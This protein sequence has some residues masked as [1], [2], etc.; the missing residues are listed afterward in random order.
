M[1]TTSVLLPFLAAL[2]VARAAAAE[3]DAKRQANTVILDANAVANLRLETVVAEP[4]TFEETVF[5]L[6]RI[7][8]FPGYRGIVS[9]RVPGRIVEIK[10]A[11]DHPIGEGEVALVLEARQVDG[12]PPRLNLTAP[13]A[14]IVS[15]VHVALGEP[16]TP[17]KSLLEIVDLEVV[18]AIA[19]VPEHSAARLAAGQAA[20]ITVV[21]ASP[22]PF[23]AEIKHVGTLA[24]PASGTV[25][26]AFRVE[27]PKLLLRPGMRAEFAIVVAERKDVTAVPRAAIQ[28]EGAS[29]FVFV[30]D[31]ALPNAFVKCPVV[32]GQANDRLVEIVSGL[33]PADEVVTRGAYSLAFAG[34]G[35]VSLKAALD[36]AHGHE[37][38]ADGTELTE[39]QRRQRAAAK[40]NSPGAAGH[41]HAHDH[42]HDHGDAHAH[43]SPFWMIVSGALFLALI[44]Q[45]IRHRRAS[46]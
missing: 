39:E 27:N 43:A 28:G 42:G 38:N 21:A 36:A 12:D 3:A 17:E 4:A 20:R 23:T 33:L 35:N 37:H 7:E 1:K 11:P 30:T 13:I 25:E 45:S 18:Y 22:D 14:G 31:F 46:A 2:M 9:T 34:T 24:D 44:V 26:A 6:G 41:D 32:L 40:P 19:R 8:V 16:V 29:R 10:T 5:A 15:A